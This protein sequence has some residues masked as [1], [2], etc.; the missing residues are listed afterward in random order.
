LIVFFITLFSKV[1]ELKTNFACGIL[2]VVVLMNFHDGK[3]EKVVYLVKVHVNEK[4]YL[5]SYELLRT[6]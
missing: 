1:I 4:Y 6:K 3:I 5:L 2:I